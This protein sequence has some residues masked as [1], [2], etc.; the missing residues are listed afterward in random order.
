MQWV[1]ENGITSSSLYEYKGVQQACPAERKPVSR[2]ESVEALPVNNEPAMLEALKDGPISVAIMVRLC[3][4]ERAVAAFIA[5]ARVNLLALCSKMSCM[6][7][8]MLVRGM[9][10]HC[11]SFD[12]A[13]HKRSCAV[14]HA[15]LG[16]QAPSCASHCKTCVVGRSW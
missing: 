3:S 15:R 9:Q 13:L 1:V 11:V 7:L 10:N 2:L 6:W 14:T 8:S 4:S 5:L 12:A 16:L